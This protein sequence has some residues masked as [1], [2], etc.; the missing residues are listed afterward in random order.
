MWR[1]AVFFLLAVIW[2]DA[3]AQEAEPRIAIIPVR[4]DAGTGLSDAPGFSSAVLHQEIEAAFHATDTFRIVSSNPMELS[5]ILDDAV[6]RGQTSRL[7]TLAVDYIIAPTVQAAELSRESF[8]IP[9]LR[10]QVRVEARA[11]LRMRVRVLDATTGELLD[12]I[13]VDVDWSG[14]P[15]VTRYDSSEARQYNFSQADFVAMSREAGRRLADAVLEAVYPVQIIA[16]DGR[17]VWLS[18]GGDAGYPVGT[19][20]RVLSGGGEPLIHPVTR[21][22]LGY[23]ET[24]LGT[25]V[26]TETQARYS[27]G[28]V[29]DEDGGVIVDGSIVRRMVSE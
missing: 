12:P 9:A 10:D 11:R 21:E 20:L 16:R 8:D 18:R 19:R 24:R 29:V 7:R 26:I 2:S 4:V 3:E 6:N 28:E 27:V 5:A 17:Q 13:P 15:T 25:I 1:L 22:I 23:R 14:D